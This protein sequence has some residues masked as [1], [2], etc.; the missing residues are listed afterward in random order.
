MGDFRQPGGAIHAG[1][2]DRAALAT[3]A[4]DDVDVD[5][6]GD[7][8]RSGRGALAGLVIR[9][10]M[11]VHEPAALRR[12]VLHAEDSRCRWVA[13]RSEEHTSELQSLM[14]ISYAVLCV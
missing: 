1:V 6:L 4:R 12:L 8:L 13:W 5:A 14:R 11:D 9:V 2:E 7:V 3:G 10:G